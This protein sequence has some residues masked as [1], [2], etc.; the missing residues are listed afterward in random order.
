MA[1]QTLHIALRDIEHGPTHRQMDLT[2][3]A[4]LILFQLREQHQP[5]VK[6]LAISLVSDSDS[7]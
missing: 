5:R 4:G 2:A 7:T 3:I 6:V 1:T